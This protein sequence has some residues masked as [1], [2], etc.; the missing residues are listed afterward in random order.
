MAYI[1]KSIYPASIGSSGSD[2]LAGFIGGKFSMF[3]GGD[4]YAQQLTEQAPDTFNWVMLP[5]L[6]G[7]SQMQNANPQTLSIATQS[8]YP[9]QAMKFI[10]YFTAAE[11][12]SSLA[13]GDWLAPATTSGGEALLA[14]TG[15]K[16][17][18]DVVVASAKTLG[19]APFQKLEAYPQ[20]KTQIATP[21]FQQ[22]FAGQIDLAALG[23]QLTDGW[24]KVSGG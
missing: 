12:V 1:D 6:K 18:W 15:G 21:A 22:F 4:F 5:L 9:E 2:N 14:A 24:T 19:F 23:T 17:G 3:V 11:N 7:D 16:H 10:T 20:W 8:K 13:Q